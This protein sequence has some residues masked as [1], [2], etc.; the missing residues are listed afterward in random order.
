[1][2]CARQLAG[3]SWTGGKWT[4]QPGPATFLNRRAKASLNLRHPRAIMRFPSLF[5]A[6]TA[7]TGLLFTPALAAHQESSATPQR[8][9]TTGTLAIATEPTRSQEAPLSSTTGMVV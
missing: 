3:V 7:A 6:G 4:G 5:I 9:G 8:P 1:M 2:G